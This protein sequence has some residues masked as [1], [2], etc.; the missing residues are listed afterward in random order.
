MGSVL[1]FAD[2]TNTPCS[3]KLDLFDSAILIVKLCG[4]TKATAYQRLG[5]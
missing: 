2:A 1:S 4:P 5:L 3:L